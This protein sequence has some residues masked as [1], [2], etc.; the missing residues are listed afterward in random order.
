MN[1]IGIKQI[2]AFIFTLKNHFLIT[3]IEFYNSLDRAQDN[4]RPQG[5]FYKSFRDSNLPA[6]GLR[7]HYLKSRGL[8]CEMRR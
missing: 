6:D 4:Q 3:F 1:F 8:L 2:L 5:L 7:V